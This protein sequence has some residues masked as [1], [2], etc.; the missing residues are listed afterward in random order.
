MKT[1]NTNAGLADLRK[2]WQIDQQTDS[3]VCLFCGASYRRG[4]IY[5]FGEVLLSSSAAITQH[6]K[7]AHGSVFAALTHDRGKSA[8]LSDIQYT[9]LAGM[10]EGLEDSQIAEKLDNRA[11]STVRAHRR[12][13]RLRYEEAKVFVAAMELALNK[14]HHSQQALDFGAAMPIHDDRVHVSNDEAEAVI[15][16]FFRPDGSLQRIPPKE[17][18]KLIVLKRLLELFETGREYSDADMREILG[19]V[20]EDY[21]LL[22]RYLIDYRFMQRSA[23][24]SR[25]WREGST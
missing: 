15:K 18:Q 9:V 23:D 20:N 21:A 2:G 7:D 6:L 4:R 19:R 16:K 13:L 12:N 10:A 5:Q 24:G 8:G 11:L 1:I 17:K 22:R 3:R 14:A 25:Y